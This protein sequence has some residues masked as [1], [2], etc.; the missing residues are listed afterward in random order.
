[1]SGTVTIK[2]S[3]NYERWIRGFD[4]VGL[5]VQV[6]GER[7]WKQATEVLYD[8][9]QSFVHVL[10]G[11]LKDS[12]DVEMEMGAGQLIGRVAYDMP[13]AAAEE[14]RGGSHAYLAR[15]WQATENVFARALPE[16][17]GDV[18]ATWR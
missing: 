8:R 2:I 17:W 16:A 18:V 4:N 6:A 9:T 13:Y 1:M 10:S 15:G 11:D 14:A 5:E 7:R 12:G 3:A